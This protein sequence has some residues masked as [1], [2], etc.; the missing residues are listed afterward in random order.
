M[1]LELWIR[2]GTVSQ[3]NS[4]PCAIN[5]AAVRKH[6]QIR[7]EIL[8]VAPCNRLLT[9][10]ITAFPWDTASPVEDWAVK[11]H[12]PAMEGMP[13]G[14]VVK[15]LSREEGV[16]DILSWLDQGGWI[17]PKHTGA[18]EGDWDVVQDKVGLRCPLPFP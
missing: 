7:A 16:R 13:K 2:G 11:V 5:A 17:V 10:T 1:K 8:Q 4:L 15:D 3:S 18:V 14:I 6:F 9:M 12:R